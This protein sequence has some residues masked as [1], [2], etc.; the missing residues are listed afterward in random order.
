MTRP[1]TDFELFEQSSA[2][3]RRLLREEELILKVTEAVGAVMEKEHISKAELAK[4]LGKTKGFISQLLSGG[5]NLT[6]RTLAD[7]VD[8]LGYRVTIAVS[9][10]RDSIS[11]RRSQRTNREGGLSE[12]HF[13]EE[14][15]RLDG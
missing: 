8:A 15:D 1:A 11:V 3:N 6:L 5:R 14:S 4:R 9:R 12:A 7:L 2:R 10:D 13:G